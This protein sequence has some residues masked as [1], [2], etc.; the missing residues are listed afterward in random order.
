MDAANTLAIIAFVLQF[1]IL[2][3]MIFISNKRIEHIENTK[4]RC[5][6]INHTFLD[7]INQLDPINP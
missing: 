1:I 7:S 4:C 5:S 3:T 6:S 2:S